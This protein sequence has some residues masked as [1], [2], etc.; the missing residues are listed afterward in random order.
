M[1]AM[2]RIHIPD[3]AEGDEAIQELIGF[4]TLSHDEEVDMLA[5]MCRAIDMA[6]PAIVPPEEKPPE[7]LRGINK[8]T[9]DELIAQQQPKRDWV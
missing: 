7:A 2:G 8:M 5:V 1:A 4:L 6:H 3:T 9:W